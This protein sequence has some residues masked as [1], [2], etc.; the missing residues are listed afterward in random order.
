M[1][2]LAPPNPNTLFWSGGGGSFVLIDTDARMTFAY[3][4]NRMQRGL[5]GDERSF[6]IIRAIWRTLGM[7]G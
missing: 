4:M 5:V 1:L 7:A 2:A 6:R 3:A